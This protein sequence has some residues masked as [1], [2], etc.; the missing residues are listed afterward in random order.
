MQRILS[1]E[2]FPSSCAL[3]TRKRVADI[4]DGSHSKDA[5]ARFID[6]ALVVLIVINVV[7]IAL[8]SVPSLMETYRQQFVILEVFSVTVFTFEYLARVWSSVEWSVDGDSNPVL[9]R[10]KFMA[11]PMALVDLLAIAPFFLS[12]LV[13][14]DLRFL[15]V[16]RL[17]RIFKLTR[18]SEAMS[19]M[20]EVLQEEKSALL[21]A[22]FI[23]LI[24][25]ILASSGIY[26]IEHDVQPDV[27]GSIP[28]AM[29]WSVVTLTTVGFGDVTPITAGGKAFGAIV[30]LVGVGMVAMPTGI[31][32]SGFANAFRRRRV[33]FEQE[34]S[35]ALEWA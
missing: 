10:L 3:S 20:F 28:S 11:S 1:A 33:S 25:L 17:L 22:G 31:L 21:A 29:W 19:T 26:L 24:L 8:E 16:L 12:F 6:I 27:F 13:G 23:M 2:K 34:L 15:R 35:I 9:A 30:A 5:L 14:F 32:A 7:A 4:L 18:Y